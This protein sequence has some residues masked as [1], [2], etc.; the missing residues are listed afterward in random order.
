MGNLRRYGDPP[1]KVAV[2]HGGPGAPGGM[3]PVAKALSKHQGVLEPLQTAVSIDGQVSELYDTLMECGEPPI[4]LIGHSWGAWLSFIFAAEHPST[5]RKLILVGSGPF[6][7]K[8]ARGIMETRLGRLDQDER[9]QIR[10]L[11]VAM[12]DPSTTD[13]SAIMTRF[14]ELVTR[15]DSFD[16][17]PV[18]ADA[19]VELQPDTFRSVWAEAERLR[20]SGELLQRI[21]RAIKCPVVSIHG[22]YDPHP[23][24]GVKVPLSKT[25]KDFRFVLLP[26]CG[27]EPWRERKAKDRFFEALAAELVDITLRAPEE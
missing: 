8:Y 25:L 12:D 1:F 9:A 21:G 4:T 2:I 26:D 20:S 18:E 23:Y 16:Q 15:A 3:A 24:E 13:K 14:G 7:E 10:S 22:D 27:H 11:M 17:M 19:E 6:E 5:T